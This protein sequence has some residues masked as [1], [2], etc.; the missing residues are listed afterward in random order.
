MLLLP[1]FAFAQDYSFSTGDVSGALT[2]GSL[3]VDN[4]AVDNAAVGHSSD[5]DLITVADGLLTIAGAVV[6]SS[7][8]NLKSNIAS[9]GPVLS[10][11]LLLNPK[12]YTIISDSAQKE[13]IGLL[14]QE[15]KEVFPELVNDEGDYMAVNYQGLIPVLINAVNEQSARNASLKN[16]I[17][18]LRSIINREE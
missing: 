9:L 12:R 2:V 10:K 17:D 18:L 13:K 7:D 11:L 16:R 15:V 6:T 1:V 8:A 14:A 3:A 4:V 5:T